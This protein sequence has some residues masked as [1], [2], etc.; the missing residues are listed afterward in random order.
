MDTVCVLSRVRCSITRTWS[1]GCSS[2][3]KIK[4]TA[5]CKLLLDH[6][7]PQSS[8]THIDQLLKTIM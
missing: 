4:Q 7:K 5:R 3:P 1:R 6:M 2:L 8:V